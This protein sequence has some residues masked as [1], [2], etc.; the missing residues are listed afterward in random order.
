MTTARRI[1][2]LTGTRADFGLMKSTLHAIAADPRLQLQLIVT[3]GGDG[4]DYD[5]ADWANAAVLGVPQAPS[6]APT[7]LKTTVVS[8]TQIN[9]AWQNNAANQTGVKI[10]RSTDGVNF[11]QIANVAANIVYYQNNGLTSGV[12]Y[13]YRV[14]A[15]NLAGDSA[16]SN[17]ANM[18]AK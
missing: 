16:Y 2:Y 8:A 5:H 13:Y 4:I 6:N 12:R 3:D 11:A 15:T 14:R 18:V 17:T 10:E 7:N 1:C 9:L